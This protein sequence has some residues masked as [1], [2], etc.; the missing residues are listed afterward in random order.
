MAVSNLFI[1]FREMA[2]SAEFISHIQAAK[3]RFFTDLR[4]CTRTDG[5]INYMVRAQ[6]NIFS[7][8][9]R[10]DEFRET[11]IEHNSRMEEETP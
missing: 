4:S 2:L 5:L 3:M 1:W 8:S 6:L 7:L 9:N 11:W 10:A